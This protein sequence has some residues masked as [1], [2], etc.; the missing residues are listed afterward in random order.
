MLN[1]TV[2]II[3]ANYLK[4]DILYLPHNNTKES[5][6]M[7]IT[8]LTLIYLLAHNH[9][10]DMLLLTSLLTDTVEF[11]NL[12]IDVSTWCPHDVHDYRGLHL[13]V[14]ASNVMVVIRA[15]QY[16]VIFHHLPKGNWLNQ[17]VV[18]KPVRE[19]QLCTFIRTYKYSLSCSMYNIQWSYIYM[20]LHP[21]THIFLPT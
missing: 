13:P 17:W 9:C 7:Y 16:I 4:R 12:L 2:N 19:Y 3:H 11:F 14:W 6:R 18:R 5:T 10:R 1:E 15:S 21:Y 8:I 20:W